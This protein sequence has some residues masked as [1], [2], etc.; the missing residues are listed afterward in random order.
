LCQQPFALFKQRLLIH[1]LVKVAGGARSFVGQ[2]LAFVFFGLAQ[3]MVFGQFARDGA[4]MGQDV[5]LVELQEGIKPVGLTFAI[6]GVARS[7][8]Q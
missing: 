4:R 2:T 5:A 8:S 3:G 7:K 6:R 1:Q